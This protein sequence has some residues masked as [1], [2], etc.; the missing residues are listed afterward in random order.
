MTSSGKDLNMSWTEE[1]AD[2][3]F[4]EVRRRAMTD[5]AFRQLALANPNAAIEKV[6]GKAVPPGIKIKIIETDPA[7]HMTFLLPQ[8]I[9]EELSEADLEKVAGGVCSTNI[10]MCA[11]NLCGAEAGR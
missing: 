9:G 2:R 6:S 1:E 4:V 8:M 5:K 3:A 10:E 7:A 11:G